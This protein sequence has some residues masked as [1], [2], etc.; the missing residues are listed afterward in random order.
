M[1]NCVVWVIKTKLWKFSFSSDSKY[2]C[3]LMTLLLK[4]VHWQ[5]HYLHIAVT[6]RR[7]TLWQ[8][9]QSWS[10]FLFIIS[11]VNCIFEII[12]LS[13]KWNTIIPTVAIRNLLGW[14]FVRL[15]QYHFKWMKLVIIKVKEDKLQ[16]T[17]KSNVQKTTIRKK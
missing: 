17:A 3:N 4:H 5:M 13:P 12:P 14:F 8:V 6:F 7:I 2:N 9:L 10:W 1:R 16:K 15:N 11:H